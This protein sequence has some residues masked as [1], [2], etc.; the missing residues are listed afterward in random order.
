MRNKLLI[1]VFALIASTM[2]VFIPSQ[3]NASE[4]TAENPCGTWAM[5]DNDG[6]VTNII[7]CQPSVCGSGTFAGVRVVLQVPANPTTHTSQGGYYNPDPEKAVTYNEQSNT[8][9]SGST[10]FPQPVTRSEIVET[11]T[12]TATIHSD[13]VTFGPNNFIDGQMEF[14]PVVT[15]TTGATISATQ[16][17]LIETKSFDEPKTKEQFEESIQESTIL[18]ENLSKFFQLLRGWIKN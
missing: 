1:L 18:K 16:G 6:R 5:L 8:F 17:E 4:C 14:T 15:S 11:T 9:S 7:V 2:S 10:S 12:I 13:A 3:A